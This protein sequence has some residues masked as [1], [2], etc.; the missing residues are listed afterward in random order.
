M[1]TNTR[2]AATKSVQELKTTN[3]SSTQGADKRKALESKLTPGEKKSLQ[4][5]K[6][7]DGRTETDVY[8][9]FSCRLDY[10]RARLCVETDTPPQMIVEEIVTLDKGTEKDKFYL[11]VI[12]LNT[13]E[14][15]QT[16]P[17]FGKWLISGARYPIC[18]EETKEATR[19]TVTKEVSEL[20]RVE[21]YFSTLFATLEEYFST[22]EI[23]Y[24]ENAWKLNW[25]LNHILGSGKNPDCSTQRLQE[26]KTKPN[27]EDLLKNTEILKALIMDRDKSVDDAVKYREF[28]GK[29]SPADYYWMLYQL[30]LESPEVVHKSHLTSLNTFI[31]GLMTQSAL[32][33]MGCTLGGIEDSLLRMILERS[34]KWIGTQ[35]LNDFIQKDEMVKS[36]HEGA[37]RGVESSLR[38]WAFM[39]ETVRSVLLPR[40]FTQH[41]FVGQLEVIRKSFKELKGIT[42]FCL[43]IAP[44]TERYLNDEV[45]A[46]FVLAMSRADKKFTVL[47][48]SALNARTGTPLMNEVLEKNIN[49]AQKIQEEIAAPV[50]KET[51]EVTAWEDFLESVRCKPSTANLVH[52]IGHWTYKKEIAKLAKRGDDYSL[53]CLR[54]LLEAGSQVYPPLLGGRKAR[55]LILRATDQGSAVYNHYMGELRRGDVD[56]LRVILPDGAVGTLLRD[57][58]RD[59]SKATLPK[60]K[61]QPPSDVDTTPISFVKFELV[62]EIVQK[63]KLDMMKEIDELLHDC[64]ICFEE[65][66]SNKMVTLHNDHRHS[67]CTTC[68]PQLSSCPFCRA[69][70]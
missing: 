26:I 5:F 43:S 48:T 68:R 22:G 54:Q 12:V 6:S 2:R 65:V 21:I 29:L 20:E 58:G 69:E 41:E 17:R 19:N 66:A 24:A 52:S 7:K 50:A 42:S 64:F 36:L 23:K 28:I 30:M 33:E 56:H 9:V 27:L 32:G 55:N 18:N 14:W 25:T 63:A 16:L 10:K 3:T 8:L 46:E 53:K 67:V 1:Y 40:Q 57:L 60:K 47:S 62:R 49:R 39:V 4:L 51:E 11:P 34:M 13:P 61:E 44:E 37:G 59:L 15:R 35:N 31:L 70:L 45:I 38:Y